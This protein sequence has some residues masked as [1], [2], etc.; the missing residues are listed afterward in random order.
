MENNHQKKPFSLR[1][2]ILSF[3]FAINGIL[4][5]V[6]SQHNFWIHL[7]A[8]VVV[9]AAGFV[10]EVSATEW[11]VL[12]LTIGSV[13]AAEAFNTAIELMVDKISP[14]YNKTAGLIKDVAAGAV[15]I[16]AIAAVVTGA[17]IFAPKIF[18]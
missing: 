12:I 9:V 4:Y 18:G 6:K 15:L 8:A 7:F 16:M 11:L 5:L 10:F 2:R 1:K 17:L 14:E 3:K 13:L